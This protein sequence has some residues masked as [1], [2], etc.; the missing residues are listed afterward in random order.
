MKSSK[1]FLG[2]LLLSTL[3]I[4]IVFIIIVLAQSP[5]L[6]KFPEINLGS[7]KAEPTLNIP[8][9]VAFTPEYQADDVTNLI[10][11]AMPTP[12]V[13][14]TEP[15]IQAMNKALEDKHRF[16]ATNLLIGATY[17]AINTSWYCTDIKL[18]EISLP[19]SNI[20]TAKMIE[21]KW[22]MGVYLDDIVF[23]VEK[24]T[25]SEPVY[26][27]NNGQPVIETKYNGVLVVDIRKFGIDGPTILRGN[28]WFGLIGKPIPG[29]ELWLIP[30]DI[31]TGSSLLSEKRL[32]VTNMANEL[33]KFETIVPNGS[34]ETLRGMYDVFEESFSLP[35]DGHIYNTF[36]TIFEPLAK[37]NGFAG[38]EGIRVIMPKVPS[39]IYAWDDLNGLPLIPESY[40]ESFA[41][42]TCPKPLPSVEDIQT[43]EQNLIP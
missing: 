12:R 38:L 9:V 11:T 28:E 14:L 43:L 27:D 24:G 8:G 26:H 29:Y 23:T 2:I 17:E 5:G 33:V 7:S 13:M 19:G 21:G 3:I 18:G 25:K 15:E 35:G 37:E 39:T 41:D 20:G 42:S 36:M 10:A 40:P 16:Q 31:I 6:I 34:D 22:E 30:R 4:G 1:Q 32:L